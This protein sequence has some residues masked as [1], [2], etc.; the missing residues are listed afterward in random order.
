M[1]SAAGQISDPGTPSPAQHEED[2]QPKQITPLRLLKFGKPEL[3]LVISATFL[4]AICAFLQHVAELLRR[5]V[6][7]HLCRFSDSRCARTSSTGSP[8][9]SSASTSLT[10]M[11]ALF[12]G[13][14][15][16]IAAS[17]CSCRLRS[18]VLRN[19]LRQDVAFFDTVR[20]GELLNRLSTDTEVIQIRRD[21]EPWRAGSSRRFMLMVR[22][23][24]VATLRHRSVKK[25]SRTKRV[26]RGSRLCSQVLV[27][28]PVILSVTPSSL[29]VHVPSGVP[30]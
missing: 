25:R 4:S 15:Y 7:R 5:M 11:L 1:H 2:D 18:L 8:S 19:M 17:R 16:T 24:P 9:C 22:H 10:A 21:G 28:V 23:R 27:A 12:S 30:A 26:P 13:V 14:L 29:V 6:G 20:V 3:P